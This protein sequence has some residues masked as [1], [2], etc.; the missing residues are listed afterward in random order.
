MHDLAADTKQSKTLLIDTIAK[1]RAKKLLAESD[2]Y[3]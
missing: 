2:E 1:V 3:F